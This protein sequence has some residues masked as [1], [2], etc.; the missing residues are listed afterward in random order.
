MQLNP[1][2]ESKIKIYLRMKHRFSVISILFKGLEIREI[3]RVA[4]FSD[5]ICYQI[6]IVLNYR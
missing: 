4:C 6:F 3:P 5:F 1:L 2:V